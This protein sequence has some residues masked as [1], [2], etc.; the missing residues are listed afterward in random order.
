MRSAPTMPL[1]VPAGTHCLVCGSDV[2]APTIWCPRCQTPYHAECYRYAGKC[3]IYG[4]AGVS[5]APLPGKAETSLPPRTYARRLIVTTAHHSIGQMLSIFIIAGVAKFA[6]DTRLTGSTLSEMLMLG[7]VGVVLTLYLLRQF[8]TV[9][10]EPMRGTVTALSGVP[11]SLGT[12]K[13]EFSIYACRYVA[14]TE[15]HVAG[16]EGPYD[17]T[18]R[19]SWEVV[20]VLDD[21]QMVSLLLGGQGDDDLEKDAKALAEAINVPFRKFV[22]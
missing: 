22:G 8:S 1:A 17:R 19:C 16:V 10:V 12:Q 14:L 4:C 18:P 3:S 7:T 20:A 15:R 13:H 6:V 21:D 5:A 2:C 11:G 9:V